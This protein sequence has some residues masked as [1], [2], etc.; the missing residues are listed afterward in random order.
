MLTSTWFVTS[1]VPLQK[2]DY[3]KREPCRVC[4]QGI[5]SPGLASQ[6]WHPTR[7]CEAPGTF[8][9]R[10]LA[11][12]VDKAVSAARLGSATSIPWILDTDYKVMV[13]VVD[14][15]KVL[16]CFAQIAAYTTQ[17]LGVTELSLT[18]HNVA[19]KLKD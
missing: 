5:A 9:V 8:R 16:R 1:E 6:Q 12:S 7:R 3:S 11:P 10:D 18:D 2:Q 17:K 19:N 13:H 14:G 4:P 15:A